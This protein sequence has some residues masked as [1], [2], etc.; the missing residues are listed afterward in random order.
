VL[1]LDGSGTLDLR[2]CRCTE[3]EVP[4][5]AER[6]LRSYSPTGAHRRIAGLLP[7]GTV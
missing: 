2:C 7:S 4:A 3:A 6:L 1:L 5:N